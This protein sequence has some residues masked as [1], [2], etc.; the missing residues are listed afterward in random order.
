MPV[1]QRHFGVQETSH[2]SEYRP[3]LHAGQPASARPQSAAGGVIF[4]D[5]CLKINFMPCPVERRFNGGEIGFSI[6]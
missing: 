2:L 3:L 5:I 6:V 1:D 4:E